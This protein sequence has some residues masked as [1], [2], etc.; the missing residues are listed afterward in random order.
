M[1]NTEFLKYNITWLKFIALALII[2]IFVGIFD[3]SK[4][5]FLSYALLLFEIFFIIMLFVI[6]YQMISIYVLTFSYINFYKTV[7]YKVG[8]NEFLKAFDYCANSSLSI[9][10]KVIINDVE[11]Y[12]EWNGYNNWK[13]ANQDGSFIITKG[14][15]QK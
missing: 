7:G 10:E 6:S 5:P 8:I 3:I 12:I 4:L 15:T 2:P 1:N 14:F 13:I 9:K 11:K